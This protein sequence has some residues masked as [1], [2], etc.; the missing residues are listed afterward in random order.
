[1]ALSLYTNSSPPLDGNLQTPVFRL[2]PSPPTPTPGKEGP[3]RCLSPLLSVYSGRRTAPPKQQPVLCL[4]RP[5][6]P[7]ASAGP[8]RAQPHRT[9]H[10]APT[11]LSLCGESR[12]V[13]LGR[14]RKCGLA[15]K[16]T[17][18]GKGV[19]TSRA[20]T[21][22]P[23]P[24]GQRSAAGSTQPAIREPGE[25]VPHP[26]P[27]PPP[28]AP[29]NKALLQSRGAHAGPTKT[30]RPFSPYPLLLSWC[31]RAQPC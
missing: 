7:K 3:G 31:P 10:P 20:T 8:R 22:L 16:Q 11:H 9:T 1:M 15:V 19:R 6:G 30:T 18:P 29:A 23:R 4:E 14:R 17:G 27:N 13:A 28:P 24:H 21:G 25:A 2:P 5:K 26:H 12:A